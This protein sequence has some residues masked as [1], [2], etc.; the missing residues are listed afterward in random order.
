MLAESLV[1]TSNSTSFLTSARG[2]TPG[3]RRQ[4]VGAGD[5]HRVWS[6]AELAAGDC[7]VRK[8]KKQTNT[9]IQEVQR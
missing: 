3:A 2:N 9:K 6:R 8:S 7:P 1:K 4:G 5:K